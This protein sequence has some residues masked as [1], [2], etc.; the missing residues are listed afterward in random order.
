MKK[1]IL[2]F[3]CSVLFVLPMILGV[4]GCTEGLPNLDTE[5]S[6]NFVVQFYN[7]DNSL[8]KEISVEENNEAICEVPTKESTTKYVYEFANWIF[9]DGT[10]ATEDL[11]KVTKTLVVK[12]KFN[13][14]QPT[15]TIKYYDEDK[16]TLLGSEEV[17]RGDSAKYETIPTKKPDTYYN[18]GFSAWVDEDGEVVD[19]EAIQ[20]NQSVYA[21]YQVANQHT[22]QIN[23]YD[24][25]RTTLLKPIKVVKGTDITYEVPDVKKDIEGTNFAYY[26]EGWQEVD[27]NVVSSF[28]NL[29]RSMDLYAKYSKDVYDKTYGLKYTISEDGEYYSASKFVGDATSVIVVSK[30]QN[31]PVKEIGS[32]AFKNN[33]TI[34]EVVIQ[35][36]VTSIGSDAFYDCWLLN[37]VQ[38]PN[39]VTS[40]GGYV[41]GKCSSLKSITLPNNLTQI[42]QNCFWLSG[43]ESITIPDSVESIGFRAFE[44]CSDLKVVIL[45]DNVKIIKSGAFSDNE[46]IEY[47]KMS[48]KLEKIEDRA[49][50]GCSNLTNITLPASLSFVGEWAFLDCDNMQSVN[51]LGT[52]DEWA[53]IEFDRLDA[54]PK[55]HLKFNGVEVDKVVITKAT[56][57]NAYAF[58][59][60]SSIKSVEIGESVVSIGENSFEGCENLNNIQFS[61]NIKSLGEYAFKN[62]TS[63]NNLKL[64]AT[65][66]INS[67]TF[68]GCTSL[69]TLTIG[70]ES[71]K[72]TVIYLDWLQYDK[73]IKTIT[74]NAKEIMLSIEDY[75]AMVENTILE[76]AILGENVE[77]IRDYAFY[78]ENLKSIYLPKSL[79]LIEGFS[80]WCTLHEVNYSGDIDDWVSIEFN[81]T[82]FDDETVLKI[83]GV[84]QTAITITKATKINNYALLNCA[85]ITSVEIGESV[86]SIGKDA[87]RDCGNLTDVIIGKNVTT[88][89]TSVF[90]GCDSLTSV[91]FGKSITSISSSAFYGCDNLQIVNYTGT[92]ND[93]LSIEFESASANPLCNGAMLK[94]DG[95]EQTAITITTATRINDYAFQGCTSITLVEIGESVNSIGKNAFYRCDNLTNVIIGESVNSIG[96]NAFYD[97]NNLTDAIL[98][99][100]VTTIGESAFCGCNSLTSVKLGK[101]ITSISSDTFYCCYNLQIVNYTGTINDWV[102]IEFEGAYANPLHNGA[103][104]KIDGVEQTAITIT[105]ATRINDYAF[106][107]CTS[108]TSVEIGESVLSIGKNAFCRCDNLTNIIIGENVNSIG[109][110]AFYDCDNLTTAI[111]NSDYIASN[112]LE[113]C[114]LNV[115]EI[116]VKSGTEVSSFISTNYTVVTEILEGEYTGYTRYSKS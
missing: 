50:Y 98:G 107:G 42:S 52:M 113:D 62:C 81:Y 1:R 70:D 26:L 29:D 36:G 16:V 100:N 14:I 114:K 8:I 48:N 76:T 88:I 55:S 30:I 109:E 10:D 46:K 105:T 97:C 32:D 22:L 33:E 93:W 51:Y 19:L 101:S 67:T 91:K 74:L 94:I 102:S 41:F 39:S 89:G 68:T 110:N 31:I 65:T 40:I 49:F 20:D 9:L 90:F 79:A 75:D 63:I 82:V 66:E 84:E 24:D 58:R 44:N 69:T 7:E 115:N 83:N 64:P 17:L 111:I 103:M 72:D 87:F 95:V 53:S 34:K 73:N 57:I 96:E 23:F 27:G 11:A 77:I 112:L 59:Y 71:D 6:Q 99:E 92:I 54:I 28:R 78:C 25:D 61:K 3:L 47:V 60:C 85:S 2:K 18:Y 37:S 45:G 38:I 12:A 108:I 15:Y 106:Q 56:K 43:L 21:T 13:E 80:F 86:V 104:L 5:K 4:V 35:D 116:Y